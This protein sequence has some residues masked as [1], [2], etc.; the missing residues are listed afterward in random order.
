MFLGERFGTEPVLPRFKMGRIVFMEETILLLIRRLNAAMEQEGRE[1]FRALGISLSQGF[2][3]GFLLGEGNARTCAAEL[4]GLFGLSR[5]TLSELLSDLK[6]KGYL[7][8]SVDPQDDRKKRLVPTPKARAVEG[9]IRK[10][11]SRQRQRLKE[12]FAPSDVE[13]ME[14]LLGAARKELQ[15][16]H[17][18]GTK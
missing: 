15:K 17:K 7:E 4:C 14:F 18:E 10:V 12:E 6:E 2:V 5:S 3:L 13:L 11:F 9:E 8:I 16:K 1:G